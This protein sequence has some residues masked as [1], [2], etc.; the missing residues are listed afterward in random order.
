M[1]EVI[2]ILVVVGNLAYF[3]LWIYKKVKRNGT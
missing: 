2:A 3:G 1:V